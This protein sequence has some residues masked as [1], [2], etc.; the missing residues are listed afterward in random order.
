MIQTTQAHDNVCI[1]DQ[2]G[3]SLSDSNAYYNVAIGSYA[4]DAATTTTHTT[5]I[6][7]A[8]GSSVTTGDGSVYIGASAGQLATTGHTN[9]FIGANA[10]YDCTTG[11]NLICIG[12]AAGY[13]A[14]NDIV[15]GRFG[16][17]IGPFT[18]ASAGNVDHEYVIGYN[19]IG[20]GGS[21]GYWNPGGG[22]VYQGNNSSSWS[23][24]SDI[25]IKK[26]IVDNTTGLDIINQI[27]IKNFEYKT[28]DEIKSASPEL[29][30]V[31]GCAVVK[32]EGT[33]LGV[34]AQ[35]IETFLPEVVKTETT[36]IKRVDS[37]NLTWYLINAVKE[38]SAENT[39]LKSLIKG[40]S[41]FANLK[42][43]L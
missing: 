34:I 15:D 28:E 31:V 35:E 26:N 40:S 43:S 11:N 17:Y 21:T 30:D 38:L 41:S 25:R 13:S 6:G 27:K 37:D 39:A 9:T 5:A 23:T 32:R 16:Q 33:Q 10:G 29:L 3:Y 36:G 18:Q 12:H 7:Y 14:G 19:T 24:T 1:G 22:G 8:A 2:A 4:L 20:K 42:S